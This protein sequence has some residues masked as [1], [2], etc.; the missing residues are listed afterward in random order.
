MLRMIRQKADDDG[1]LLLASAVFEKGLEDLGSCYHLARDDAIAW[2]ERE[3]DGETL[4][5]EFLC[6]VLGYDAILLKRRILNGNGRPSKEDIKQILA[7][8]AARH[9]SCSEHAIGE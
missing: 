4:T 6:E 5:F 1:H 7:T 9:K 3:D 2:V 8:A